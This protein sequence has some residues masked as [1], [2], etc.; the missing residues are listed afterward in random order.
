MTT[1]TAFI[2]KLSDTCY[3]VSTSENPAGYVYKAKDTRDRTGAAV[4][5][6]SLAQDYLGALRRYGY[7]I[8]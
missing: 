7:Q 3:V 2:R 1:K 4:S 5:A 8:A 6:L